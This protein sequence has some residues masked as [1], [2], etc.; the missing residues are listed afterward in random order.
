MHPGKSV[1]VK[2]FLYVLHSRKRKNIEQTVLD[3]WILISVSASTKWNNVIILSEFQNKI[4][5]H[6]KIGYQQR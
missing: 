2:C 6:N 1:Q 5:F 3:W 4:K